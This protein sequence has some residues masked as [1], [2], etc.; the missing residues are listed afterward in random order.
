MKQKTSLLIM[1]LVGVLFLSSSILAVSAL[2]TPH[3][4]NPVTYSWIQCTGSRAVGTFE[5]GAQVGSSAELISWTVPAGS[6]ES[7]PNCIRLGLNAVEIATYVSS[8]GHIP[9]T[10]SC[11]KSS[12]SGFC[13][14]TLQIQEFVGKG[15]ITVPYALQPSDKIVVQINAIYQNYGVHGTTVSFSCN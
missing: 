2:A 8:A 11:V 10:G 14:F 7:A 6:W 5:V 15:Y 3:I 1:S 13:E 4:N 9:V 12:S